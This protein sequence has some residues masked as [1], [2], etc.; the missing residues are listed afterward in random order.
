MHTVYTVHCIMYYILYTVYTVHCVVCILYTVYTV[1]CVN[2]TLCILY[3]V[4][5]VHCKKIKSFPKIIVFSKLNL[6]KISL[7]NQKPKKPK[8]AGKIE[9]KT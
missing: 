5:T 2:C 7:A 4:Y 6:R 1:H 9:P 8:I 3:T